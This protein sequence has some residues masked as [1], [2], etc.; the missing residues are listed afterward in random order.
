[1]DKR[2]LIYI[3][4]PMCSWCWGFSP[5]IREIATQVSGRAEFSI[6]MGG[7]RSDTGPMSE[8]RR[9]GVR[10]HWIRVKESTGQPFMF[11]LLDSTTFVYDTEPACRAV[12]TLRSMLGDEAALDMFDRLQAAFYAHNHD[13]S[14]V[15]VAA[16]I[17]GAAGADTG[18]FTR[19]MNTQR[20]KR[21]TREDFRRSQEWGVRGFPSILM[22]E[23]G[24]AALLTRG[25][26]PYEQLREPLM[27]WLEH[28]FEQ[29]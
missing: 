22:M 2:E 15:G 9:Q 24:R 3:A 16:R 25:Y 27:R 4:D 7:L 18:E 14:Q 21:K 28:G 23:A 13:I 10:G 11:D 1:M 12:V 19:L 29:R 20:L 5:V 8:E 6:V 17:A 26:Q